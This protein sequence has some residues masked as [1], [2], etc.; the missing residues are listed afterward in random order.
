[1]NMANLEPDILLCEWARW[2]ADD[3][4]EALHLC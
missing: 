1:M 2:R 4:L 3:V